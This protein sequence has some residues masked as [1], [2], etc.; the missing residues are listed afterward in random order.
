MA[1]QPST[2]AIVALVVGLIPGAYF[3]WLVVK[4]LILTLRRGKDEDL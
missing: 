1:E 3:V 2:L 4:G